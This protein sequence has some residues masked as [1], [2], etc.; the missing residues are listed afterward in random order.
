MNG[1]FAGLNWF[2]RKVASLGT[3]VHFIKQDGDKMEIKY[4]GPKTRL[5]TFTVGQAYKQEQ[6]SGDITN[7]IY[8]IQINGVDLDLS[9]VII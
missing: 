6:H 4:T 1:G 8:H 5:E 3:P 9:I 2:I 7:V